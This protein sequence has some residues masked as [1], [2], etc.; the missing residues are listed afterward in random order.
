MGELAELANVTKRTVD[1]Y[2]TKGLLKAS[3]S[4]SNYRFY[5][6]AAIDQLGFIEECKKNGLSLEEIK[7]LL[8]C[9]DLK[10]TDITTASR[11]LEEKL[12]EL[13]TDLGTILSM[14]ENADGNSKLHLKKTISRE[15]LSLI[16]TLLLL[17]V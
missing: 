17:L 3:R 16:Q 13:N 9:R 8:I 1:Y 2:T 4:D 6:K 12:K 10:E 15:S 5:D 14:L 7:Q 11:E